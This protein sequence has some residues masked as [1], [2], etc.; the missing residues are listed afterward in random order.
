[1]RSNSNSCRLNHSEIKE[2]LKYDRKDLLAKPPLFDFPVLN[3]DSE[4]E[5]NW[6]ALTKIVLEDPQFVKV[7]IESS[8]EPEYHFTGQK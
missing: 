6:G 5:P 4:V 3:F 2:I 7:A 1:M 8:K